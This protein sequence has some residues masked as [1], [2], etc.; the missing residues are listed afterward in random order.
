MTYIFVIIDYMYVK[1]VV[2]E[3]IMVFE[4]NILLLPSVL[5]LP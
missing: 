1:K 5:L 4:S 3:G 2:G